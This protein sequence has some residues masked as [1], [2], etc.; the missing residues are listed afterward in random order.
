[1][2]DDESKVV[3]LVCTGS[4]IRLHMTLVLAAVKARSASTCLQVIALREPV[5]VNAIWAFCAL[6]D[7]LPCE[8]VFFGE[9]DFDCRDGIS[10]DTFETVAMSEEKEDLVVTLLGGL[11]SCAQR[12][13]VYRIRSTF[14]SKCFSIIL[15]HSMSSPLSAF[16]KTMAQGI[17]LYCVVSRR[18]T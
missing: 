4:V 13:V 15:D 11:L 10:L 5:S 8:A 9:T 3:D 2:G 18:M 17:R 1:M 14:C 7:D 16:C 6:G 12:A